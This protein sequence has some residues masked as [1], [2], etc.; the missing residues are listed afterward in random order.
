MST[1]TPGYAMT[2]R[3]EGP[4]LD[5]FDP[6]KESENEKQMEIMLGKLK[7]SKADLKWGDF[8]CNNDPEPYR[9]DGLMMFNG[10]KLVQLDFQDCFDEYGH[11]PAEFEVLR[12]HPETKE[13]ILPDYW[14]G[15]FA[16]NRPDGSRFIGHNDLVNFDQTKHAD[17]IIE[18]MQI[19][20]DSKGECSIW[21]RFT[22]HG[23]EIDITIDTSDLTI[24]KSQKAKAVENFT[25]IIKTK[26]GMMFEC[27]NSEKILKRPLLV[28]RYQDLELNE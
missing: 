10:K 16:K 15:I 20:I 24:E 14:H 13:L 17:E 11:L 5:P 21:S 3:V 28:V 12:L 18:N 27:A 26:K 6:E 8:V 4:T 7:K 19:W 2:H 22:V 25:R 9:N 23:K 1:R